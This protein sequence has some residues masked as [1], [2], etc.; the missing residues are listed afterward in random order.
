VHWCCRYACD[1]VRHELRGWIRHHRWHALIDALITR[2]RYVLLFKR[3]LLGACER[4]ERSQQSVMMDGAD[5]KDVPASKLKRLASGRSTAADANAG[6][7]GG[8]PAVLVTILG[9]EKDKAERSPLA[10]PT[11]SSL[12]ERSGSSVS[13]MSDMST[14]P[15]SA[16][17]WSSLELAELNAPVDGADP[18]DVAVLWWRALARV[19]VSR[20]RAVRVRAVCVPYACCVR[21]VCVCR[22]PSNNLVKKRSREKNDHLIRRDHCTHSAPPVSLQTVAFDRLNRMNRLTSRRSDAHGSRLAPAASVTPLDPMS[23]L[24][25]RLGLART[26]AAA[27]ARRPVAYQARQPARLLRSLRLRGGTASPNSK[28]RGLPPPLPRSRARALR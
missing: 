24:P 20:V 9:D 16:S 21:A 4:S 6:S 17:E 13:D 19:E 10:V 26:T 7:G 3:S 5:Q 2:R 27:G 11:P 8:F 12:G 22:V 25:S 15:L 28:R 18:S 1:A 14:T 23:R